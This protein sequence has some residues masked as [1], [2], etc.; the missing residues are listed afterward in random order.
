MASENPSGDLPTGLK[1]KVKNNSPD[2]QETASGTVVGVL[3][4]QQGDTKSWL[5]SE[6]QE[7][8]EITG[9]FKEITFQFSVGETPP[10][11]GA[12]LT[13]MV[14]YQGPLKYVLTGAGEDS[15]VAVGRAPLKPL[16]LNPKDPMLAC[17]DP[18]S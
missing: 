17:G 2:N 1:V 16:D 14:V 4:V 13:L 8:G 15:A 18:E 9:A 7:K 12:T 6:A 10:S 5:V 11:S 3:E